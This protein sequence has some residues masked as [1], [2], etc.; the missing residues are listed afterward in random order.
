MLSYIR[1]NGS[2]IKE[3]HVEGVHSKSAQLMEIFSAFTEPRV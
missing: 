1:Y 2:F 3:L